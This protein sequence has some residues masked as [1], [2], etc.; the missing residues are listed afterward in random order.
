MQDFFEEISQLV[1][2]E[3]PVII[4]VMQDTATKK[5]NKKIKKLTETDAESLY[6]MIE[7]EIGEGKN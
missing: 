5:K 3:S 4:S 2:A 6:N 1:E 7:K